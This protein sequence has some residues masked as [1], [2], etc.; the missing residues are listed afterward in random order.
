MEKLFSFLIYPFIHPVSFFMYLQLLLSDNS[1][2]L[3]V[4]KIKMAGWTYMAACGLEQGR[5]ETRSTVTSSHVGPMR[6]TQVYEND[7][8]ITMLQFAANMMKV[9]RDF[10]RSSF[11]SFQG[12]NLKIGKR[13]YCS[14][15][16]PI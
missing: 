8:I 6:P 12:T 13:L 15:A 4:E 11:Q 14:K 3:K 10:N 16:N 5:R 9:L 2:M 7:V 1:Q